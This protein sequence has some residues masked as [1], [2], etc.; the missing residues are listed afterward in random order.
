MQD[1]AMARKQELGPVVIIFLNAARNSLLKI[2]Y[3]TGLKHEFDHP[4]QVKTLNAV[5]GMQS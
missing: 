3:I 5:G 2:E 4:S 1:G